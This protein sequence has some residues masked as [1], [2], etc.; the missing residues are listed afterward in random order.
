[1]GP[2]AAS[3]IV[4]EFTPPNLEARG[5]SIVGQ[6]TDGLKSDASQP[7]SEEV[8]SEQDLGPK[9]AELNRAS[10]VALSPKAVSWSD[11]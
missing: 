10:S 4:D 5:E 6:V 7:A 3:V 11:C 1:M 8:D 9:V 2:P